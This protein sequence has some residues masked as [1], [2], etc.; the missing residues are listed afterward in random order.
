MPGYERNQAAIDNTV[1]NRRL[2]LIMLT[3]VLDAA[4]V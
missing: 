1:E 2:G 3:V 4:V